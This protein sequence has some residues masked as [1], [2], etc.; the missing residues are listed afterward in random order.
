MVRKRKDPIPR[1]LE[2]RILSILTEY[3]KINNVAEFAEYLGLTRTQ[4]AGF[5]RTSRAKAA[6]ATLSPAERIAQRKH[7]NARLS[8]TAQELALLVDELELEKDLLSSGYSI[9]EP[10]ESGIVSLID[11]Y[12]KRVNNEQASSSCAVQERRRSKS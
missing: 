11:A 6:I 4:V 12:H 8:S 5:L 2:D 3:G 9:T 7:L 1:E 10:V